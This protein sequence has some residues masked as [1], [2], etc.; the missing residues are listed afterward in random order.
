MHDDDHGE[1]SYA[2]R[3]RRASDEDGRRFRRRQTH[4]VA[5]E[6]AGG[7]G[8][9][10]STFRGARAEG[11]WCKSEGTRR[12]RA[13]VTLT[14]V[15]AVV[16]RLVEQDGRDTRDPILVLEILWLGRGGCDRGQSGWG[17]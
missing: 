8:L 4:D 6:V 11:E 1:C 16:L 9:R 5:L 12:R 2:F 3:D 14:V 15:V 17:V 7:R 13:T 10:F